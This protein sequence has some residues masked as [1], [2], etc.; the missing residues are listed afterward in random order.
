MIGLADRDA[1]QLGQ[2]TETD[3]DHR[4]DPAPSTERE[5]A[6]DAD[7]RGYCDY[8][9]DALRQDRRV[10][11]DRQC[12]H[13]EALDAEA[14]G[15]HRDGIDDPQDRDDQDADRP[16]SD[17]QSGL[18]RRRI[19]IL[20]AVQRHDADSRRRAGSKVP[21]TSRWYAW[22]MIPKH[23]PWRVKRAVPIGAAS[24]VPT[25]RNEST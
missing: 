22:P 14:D 24:D 16:T 15:G 3:E 20:D 11:Q 9:V 2:Q 8:D 6:E 1:D 12:V 21:I 7:D 25:T 17:P 4:Q 5:Q 18:R 19:R 23:P 13:R 10:F